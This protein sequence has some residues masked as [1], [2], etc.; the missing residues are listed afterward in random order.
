MKAVGFASSKAHPAALS[1]VGTEG[2]ATTSEAAKTAGAEVTK[3][4][5]AK[6]AFRFPRLKESV[7]RMLW[8]KKAELEQVLRQLEDQ[9][10]RGAMRESDVAAMRGSGGGK[11]LGRRGRASDGRGGAL[12]ESKDGDESKSG[13]KVASGSSHVEAMMRIFMADKGPAEKLQLEMIKQSFAS[14]DKDGK[15]HVTAK[16]VGAFLKDES[17]K[18][19]NAGLKPGGAQA[20]RDASGD[21]AV[22]TWIAERDLA[23]DGVV[24]FAEFVAHFSKEL[25]P[26]SNVMD[27]ISRLSPA[28]QRAAGGAAGK[29]DGES[30]T[31][32]AGRA[33]REAASKKKNNALSATKGKLAAL[34][35]RHTGSGRSAL[36]A[37]QT[38][39][40]QRS[41]DELVSYPGGGGGG[42]SSGARVG[43]PK[44]RA[45][46]R[47]RGLPHGDSEVKAWIRERDLTQE[48]SIGFPEFVAH[49]ASSFLPDYTAAL[50]T[51]DGLGAG[52]T[53]SALMPRTRDTDFA[54]ASL[55][56][57][58]AFGLLKLFCTLE[59]VARVCAKALGLAEAVLKEPGNHKHWKIS[60]A[61]QDF[62]AIGRC[63]GGI[64]LVEALGFRRRQPGNSAGSRSSSRRA[65]AV[66]GD[67]T[68][69]GDADVLVL[70]PNSRGWSADGGK[71]KPPKAVLT[72]LQERCTD[73]KQRM[74]ALQH[75]AIADV[76]AAVAAA[77]ALGLGGSNA[78]AHGANEWYDAISTVG[79]SYLANIIK[80]PKD[81]RYRTVSG[82]NSV[83]ARRVSR[84]RGGVELMVSAGFREDPNSG[85][86]SSICLFRT[87]G[88]SH[89]FLR[90]VGWGWGRGGEGERESGEE[91][92]DDDDEGETV[93]EDEGNETH[94]E[95]C[96]PINSMT[97]SCVA[98]RP[99]PLHNCRR[100]PLSSKPLL[101]R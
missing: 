88:H 101:G 83:F 49:H 97:N 24:S 47:S 86:V 80:K 44:V 55:P 84:L 41:F 72:A 82:S 20:D 54:V 21:D 74:R 51:A 43:A 99:H 9:R 95:N 19:R 25:L 66:A 52:A 79:G 6:A 29:D 78:D 11:R 1:L 48:G 10:A 100:A 8:R 67:S 61:S 36:H 17:A 92:D 38:S 12:Q 50:S 71:S 90:G 62:D 93:D 34:L 87:S 73:L 76:G 65:G 60:T 5:K 53:S 98:G 39:S 81:K 35:K 32:R 94:K 69:T 4:S 85:A 45:F 27:Y 37:E 3:K 63:R 89:D 31:D 96:F 56:V 58:S 16:D 23:M 70:G 59:V 42:G 57:A 64:D 68:S 77:A 14:I 13:K 91:K 30:Q 40:L 26:G 22:A 18:D 7:E 33:E 2:D 75:P 15:G 28:Q 46:L